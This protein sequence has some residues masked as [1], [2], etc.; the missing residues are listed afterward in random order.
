MS[1]TESETQIFNSDRPGTDLSVS[2]NPDGTFDFMIT[3]YHSRQTWTARVHPFAAVRIA[4]WLQ[5]AGAPKE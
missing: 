5:E 1:K 3:S 4:K 2:K